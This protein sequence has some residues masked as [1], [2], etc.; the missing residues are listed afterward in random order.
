VCDTTAAGGAGACRACVVDAHCPGDDVCNPATFT[1]VNCYSNGV[2]GADPGCQAVDGMNPRCVNN[3]CGGCTGPGDCADNPRG[4]D[5]S[6]N[7]GN[8]GQ[9]NCDND[10][11]CAHDEATGDQC[12]GNPGV[13]E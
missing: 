13:C 4:D 9:C 12:S 2:D 1:C 8:P 6:G 3:T 7:N 11:D 5:C 10:N